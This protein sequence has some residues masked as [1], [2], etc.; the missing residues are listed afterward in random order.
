MPRAVS[1]ALDLSGEA[2]GAVFCLV[3]VVLSVSNQI[4][5][6][7]STVAATATTVTTVRGLVQNSAHV[8]AKSI[9]LNT[10]S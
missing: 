3:A 9:E 8:A 1:F 10:P 7:D 4:S 2:D 5:D 6:A